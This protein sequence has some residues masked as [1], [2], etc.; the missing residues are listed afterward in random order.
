MRLVVCAAVCL[1]ASAL[2][3]QRT[4]IVVR[5]GT[6]AAVPYAFVQPAAGA[7]I[8]LDSAGRGELLLRG[9]D[10][11][12]VRVRRIGYTPLDRWVRLP[13]SDSLV[14]VMG[15]VVQALSAVEVVGVRDTPLGRRGFYDRMDRVKR[16]ATV[17]EFVTP[18]QLELQL[19]MTLTQALRDSRYA[20]LG[21]LNSGLP[22]LLGR[23][24]CAMNIVVD[25]Q[26]V[27]ATSQDAVVEQHP[28]SIRREG[29]YRPPPGSPTIELNS[30]VGGNEIAAIEVYP[31]VANA[32]FELQ[33]AV[34]SGRGTCGIVAVWT[35]GRK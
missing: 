13:V 31:S 25:G 35:G 26:Y 23:G 1:F 22:V 16:G 6:G 20:R 2:E 30:I 21:R 4:T 29:T 24:G 12:H 7:P 8:T 28:T 11:M 5:D 14:L 19:P 17:G 15:R 9:R 32:P 18:E 27:R 34:P 3:A 10:S 33:A